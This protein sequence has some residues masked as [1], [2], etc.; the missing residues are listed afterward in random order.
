MHPTVKIKKDYE[1]IEEIELIDWV[2]D[3]LTANVDDICDIVREK[4]YKCNENEVDF[5]PETHWE[6]ARAVINIEE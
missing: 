3:D 4:G 2:Q 5:Y 6:R 1:L